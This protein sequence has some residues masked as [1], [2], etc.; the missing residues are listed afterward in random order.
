MTVEQKAEEWGV[1]T[2]RWKEGADRSDRGTPELEGNKEVEMLRR[3]GEKE[4]PK[5]ELEREMAVKLREQ[6]E[7]MRSFMQVQFE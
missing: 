2:A 7:Q 4:A 3:E 6:K 1:A 5:A